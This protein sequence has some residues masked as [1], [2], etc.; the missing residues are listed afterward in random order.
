MSCVADALD[1]IQRSEDDFATVLTAIFTR[2]YTG[3]VLLHCVN[4][5]PKVVEFPS[6]QVRLRPGR[7][8]SPRDLPD[9]T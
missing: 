9:A 7:L 5:V 2:G 4:G 8:D 1:R 3:A 6:Q